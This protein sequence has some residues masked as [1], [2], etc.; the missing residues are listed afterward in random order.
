MARHV[1]VESVKEYYAEVTS[2]SA[3]MQSCLPIRD[4]MDA[5]SAKMRGV[6]F[7][8]RTSY[9]VYVYMDSCPYTLGYI[10]YADYG[11]GTFSRTHA[12]KY[13]VYSRTIV[14]GKFASGN[15]NRNMLMSTNLNVA[16]R[17]ALANLRPYD[18]ADLAAIELHKLRNAYNKG[19]SDLRNQQAKAMRVLS[20]C[21][22]L[23]T[24]LRQL[25]ANNHTFVNA[26]FAAQAKVFVESTDHLDVLDTQ[27]VR[28]VFVRVTEDWR[29]QVFQIQSIEPSR[30]AY[31]YDM[32][33]VKSD[34]SSTETPVAEVSETILGRVSVL[35]MLNAEGYVAGVGM[36]L[37]EDMF[38]VQI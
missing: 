10:G 3:Q 1:S 29:G 20:E 30:G 17:N 32:Q 31:V 23:A 33:I 26:D 13:V 22:S 16:V 19:G 25:L 4:F 21:G 12:A 8:F 14:N 28:H 27:Q 38:Y 15:E 24:E 37:T 35:S 7:L 6:K 11:G 34:G 5:L 18:V 9:E 2:A 36:K